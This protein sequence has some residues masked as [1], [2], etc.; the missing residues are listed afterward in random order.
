MSCVW[1]I[2][3]K[4]IKIYF[5]EM[6]I[7]INKVNSDGTVWVNGN[8]S[9]TTIWYGKETPFPAPDVQAPGYIL[10]VA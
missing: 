4:L 8:S 5:L 2:N 10:H 9:Q 1:E 6:T 3:Q 7:V